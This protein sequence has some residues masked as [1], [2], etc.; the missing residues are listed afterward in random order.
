MRKISLQWRLTLMTAFVIAVTCIILNLLLYNTGIFYMDSLEHSITNS[1][2]NDESFYIEFSNKDWNEFSSRFS[3]QIDDTKKNYNAKSWVIT[4][5]TTLLSGVITYFVSGYALKPLRKFSD[6]VEKIQVENLTE[7]K[8]DEHGVPEFQKISHSYNEMLSRLSEAFSS[9]RQ[10]NGNAAHEFRTPL[11][12]MKA[13]LDLYDETPHP[14]VDIEVT[15]TISMMREQTDRLSCLVKSLLDMSEMQMISRTD[16]I[17]LAALIDEVL[18]DLSPLAEKN[19][20]SL[21]QDCTENL[22]LLG[23]DILIYRL[24]FNLVE[25]AIRYNRSNGNIKI[26]TKEQKSH[27]IITIADTGYGIPKEYQQ[28]IFEPFYRIDKSRRRAF[29]G[30]GLGLTLVL[31]IVELHNGTIRIASSSKDGTIFEITLPLNGTLQDN[32][33]C[34]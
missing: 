26:E 1:D 4:L 22:I 21:L 34:H 3:L 14:N 30:V 2:S 8:V 23:S 33:L 12:M 25:N 31:K 11:A 7:C 6:Q 16:K 13:Q 5:I 28:S 10:F 27:V 24:I 9:L 19:N 15:E 29:G 32:S 17:D 20:V 18:T